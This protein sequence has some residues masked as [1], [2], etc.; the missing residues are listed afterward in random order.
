M[1]TLIKGGR[2]VT[3]IDS[4]NADVLVEG[5]TIAAVGRSIDPPSDADVCD[6]S[7]KL[8]LPG[9]IDAHVHVA[10]DL[11]GHLSSNFRDTTRTAAFGGVTTI[12]TYATAERGQTLGEA[13]EERKLQAEGDCLI[14]FGLH[15]TLSNW[16]E[17]EDDEVLELIE[18]GVPSFKAYTVYSEAGLKSDE[19]QLYRA[20]L[21]AG[22]HGG[23]VEVH[24]END[25]MIERRVRRLAKEGRLS[26]VDHAA[27]RPSYVEGESVAN[28][29]RIAYD[30]GVPVYVVHVST[31]E[32]M[33]A[34]EEAH[35]LG[36]DVY[37]E[38]CP[39]LLLLDE[40]RLAG[41]DGQRY[42]TCPP[43]RARGHQDSLWEGLEE[44][45]IQVLATD[46]CEFLASDKD[47]GASDFRKLPMGVPGV[48]TLLPL[49]WHHGVSAGR[50]T[51]NDMVERLCTQPAEV[52]GLHPRKGDLA[53]GSDADVVLF[54][55][56]LRV[57]IAPDVLH[58]HADYSPYDGW[59]VTGWPVSTMVRGR[60]V[61]TDRK[62]T[63]DYDVGR[64]VERGKVCQGPGNRGS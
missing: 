18:A 24:C 45:L 39:H 49:M 47:A 13:V 29:L 40:T 20:F 16:N 6:A 57:T 56:E 38:T 53:S 25:W 54:D 8:V 1:S 27:S 46:H 31:V 19:E 10:L 28:V 58:G 26:P 44:G 2:I 7:G 34:I 22:R 37:A 17:R 23:L 4:F 15:A 32:S 21:V 59:E 60:W 52:F 55:P 51:E 30:A 14:D 41:E 64:F 63:G 12:L 9:V 43:L 3:A 48:G 62:L 42:A 35:E 36:L 61:V 50:M 11:K 5:E 33:E